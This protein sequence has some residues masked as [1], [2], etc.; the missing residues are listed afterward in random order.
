MAVTIKDHIILTKAAKSAR[1]RENLLTD[2][3]FTHPLFAHL[4]NENKIINLNHID[5]FPPS[6]YG[7]VVSLEGGDMMV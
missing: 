1:Y 7:E 3:Y 2:L 4:N 5:K 6:K